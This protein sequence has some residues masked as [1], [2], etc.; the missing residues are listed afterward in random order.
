MHDEK[1]FSVLETRS[2]LDRSNSGARRL[3]PRSGRFNRRS[4]A[5]AASAVR[6]Q[7]FP[8]DLK[9]RCGLL[10]LPLVKIDPAAHPPHRFLAAPA[11]N[12]VP[13]RPLFAAC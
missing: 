12:N 7:S 2:I 8:G 9:P 13:T 10:W 1:P 4:S 6:C 11:G 5:P 3:D